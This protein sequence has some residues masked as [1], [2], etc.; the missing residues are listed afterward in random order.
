MRRRA[1]ESLYDPA[2]GRYARRL[3]RTNGS[4]SLDP[5]PD[6]SLAGLFLFGMLGPQDEALAATM[7]AVERELWCGDGIG[8]MARYADDHYHRVCAPAPGLPGNPWVIC[9][10]WLADWYLARGRWPK[11]LERAQDLL[12][13]VADR[14]L[15]SGVL[16]EQIHPKTGA[17]ISVSP[18]TWSHAG[19]V[20]TVHRYLDCLRRMQVRPGRTRLAP[21]SVNGHQAVISRQSSVARNGDQPPLTDDGAGLPAGKVPAGEDSSGVEQS[22]ATET[23]ARAAPRK[24]PK[25]ERPRL[26]A[27]AEA[28]HQ[29][30]L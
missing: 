17:P 12:L 6:S 29:N 3:Y 28:P 30:D 21:V 7:E 24:P 22:A 15:P 23:T 1:Q 8:G 14:A 4:W 9:T 18:L 10:L 25:Q 2:L 11:D 27:E 20:G 13:W 26:S 19:F 16:A 5:V